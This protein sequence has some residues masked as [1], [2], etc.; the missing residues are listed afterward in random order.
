MSQDSKV[1]SKSNAS[2]DGL[3]G[4]TPA[5]YLAALRKHGFDQLINDD[6]YT[7]RKGEDRL[8]LL[9]GVM[10]A[11]QKEFHTLSA[12][13]S[14]LNSEATTLGQTHHYAPDASVTKNTALHTGDA[15]RSSL[16]NE[17]TMLGQ[18]H[19]H[20]PDAFIAKTI[21]LEA[22][23]ANGN[24]ILILERN[25]EVH[26]KD[27]TILIT[28]GQEGNA[29]VIVENQLYSDVIC[30]EENLPAGKPAKYGFPEALGFV[31][32]SYLIG[33][34]IANLIV[35]NPDRRVTLI[36]GEAHIP[37]I[38]ASVNFFL[39]HMGYENKTFTIIPSKDKN[40]STDLES[41]LDAKSQA[42]TSML[43]SK[44]PEEM[45]HQSATAIQQIKEQQAKDRAEEPAFD[46]EMDNKVRSYIREILPIL[47][48]SKQSGY[49]IR[50]AMEK[51]VKAKGSLEQARAT[52]REIVAKNYKYESP[53]AYAFAELLE[54][55]HSLFSN[56]GIT[57]TNNSASAIP[58]D[59]TV[60]DAK[61]IV[62]TANNAAAAPSVDKKPDAT[63]DSK[64]AVN[65]PANISNPNQAASDSDEEDNYLD[66]FSSDF[67]KSKADLLKERPSILSNGG[68]I[69]TGTTVDDA[70]K[71]ATR[72]I[73]ASETDSVA[74]SV[75]LSTDT[76]L[77]SNKNN[78]TDSEG[79]YGST[80]ELLMLGT[81][82][83]PEGTHI[84]ASETDTDEDEE[85]LAN[86]EASSANPDRAS[87]VVLNN[88]TASAEKEKADTKAGGNIPP[89]EADSDED[90]ENVTNSSPPGMER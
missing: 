63:T 88:S 49:L 52:A 11:A 17:I 84:N 10:L 4:M 53:R 87:N 48:F 19:D 59:T 60:G 6:L 30:E 21:A 74:N 57:P 8:P 66:L 78:A 77:T 2:V 64:T 69:P 89:P 76:S 75:V 47:G 34:Y 14:S 22:G 45:T 25:G 85:D 43:S 20:A 61:S 80:W 90:E 56:G 67:G 32:R 54:N 41:M 24:G 79:P 58:T 65:K 27:P 3:S 36:I 28:Q 86:S 16:N 7:K 72:N 23:G 29:M 73:N 38:C 50:E 35:A 71:N 15:K 18:T 55:G 37:D 51:F 33:H 46:L 42:T 13:R 68:A 31:E 1:N 70:K 82:Q 40:R 26:P 9:M 62:I 81:F 44:D 39:K 83:R 12:S 5:T